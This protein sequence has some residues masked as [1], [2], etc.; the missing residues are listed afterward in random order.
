MDAE[1]GKSRI[2]AIDIARFYAMALVFYGHF[3]EELMLLEN[4]AAADQYRFIYS[5]HMVLFIV[6]AGTVAK[7]NQV[8]WPFR[9]FVKSRFHS[10]LVPFCFFTLVMMI[11]PFF[12]DGKF[13]GLELPSIIGYGIGLIN[14]AFGLPSFCIPSWFLLL[15][16]GVEL[17][18]YGTF[19]FIK[20]ANGKLLFAAIGFYLVGYGFNLLFDPFN[21]L[22]GRTVGWNYFFIHEAITLYPFYLLGIVLNRKGLFHGKIPVRI[23]L[24]CAAAGLLFVLFTYRLNTGPFTFHVY[25]Y[26]VI[27]FSSHGHIL[28][29]P[30]TALAGCA[31]V[32]CIA[33]MTPARKTMVWLGQNTLVLMCLNGIFYHYVNPPTAQWVLENCPSSALGVLGVGTL[34]TVASLAL[35]APLVFLFNRWVPQLVGKPK[36][37]GLLLQRLHFQ[38]LPVALYITF[39]FLPLL[40][41]VSLSFHST[42]RGTSTPAGELTLLNYLHIFQNPAL[43]ASI[44]NSITYVLLNILITI[45]VAFLAAYAFSRYRF[46]GDG[47]LFFGFLTL[48]MTPPVVM[49]L[50]VFLV[51]I[52]VNLVNTPLAIALAH[53]LFN[54]PISIW[55]LEGFLSSIPKELDETAFLDGYSLV[56][57]FWKI[58]I[59]LMKPGIAVATFFCFLFSWVE[60]V[61]ARI[62]TI[63]AGK[64]ISMAISSLFTFK[65]DMGLVAAMTVLSIFPGALLVVFVRGHIA[66]GFMVR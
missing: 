39:L 33:S 46:V 9:K 47:F 31:L 36:A 20:D 63:T 13:F 55:V 59:P 58:L 17:V 30:L 37:R 50:P 49:L 32:L 6:L 28:L 40:S 12:L 16:I 62:L 21:P 34:M 24:P 11:P 64:P 45:P 18:H 10:R 51:F 8:D 38:W 61:F 29:F 5:F 52:K 65:T 35:C 42:L 44:L 1:S 57:F 48:R 66:K 27:L 14:T 22:K 54:V 15:I 7:E 3:V 2:A 41:L 23:L 26:V 56:Q 25:P 60:V 19:R 53:C 43:T 4:P